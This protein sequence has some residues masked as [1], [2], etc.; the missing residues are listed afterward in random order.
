[1]DLAGCQ[2][3][4]N[5]F[6]GPKSPAKIEPVI[7]SGQSEFSFDS[8]GSAEGYRDW[9]EQRRAA[10]RQLAARL[11][12]PL[13][14]KVEVWLQGEIRLTGI[15]RLREEL[16]FVPEEREARLELIVDNVPFSAAEIISCVCAE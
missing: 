2:K 10:M 12:L 3:R 15:L 11:G 9:Q 16:L 1:M 6:D 8:T 4:Q 14:R 5:A 13:G 7:T